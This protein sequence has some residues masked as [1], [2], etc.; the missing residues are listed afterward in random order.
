MVEGILNNKYMTLSFTKSS[1]RSFL[2]AAAVAAFVLLPHAVH[3]QSL[4][5]P[6]DPNIANPYDSAEWYCHEGGGGYGPTFGEV[7]SICTA[8]ELNGTQ[9]VGEFTITDVFGNVAEAYKTSQGGIGYVNRSITVYPG[10]PLT[11]SWSLDP[12]IFIRE[13][14]C[15]DSVLG[16]CVQ[17]NN[18][19]ASVPHYFDS[20]I[21]STFG[22]TFQYGTVTITAPSSGTATSTI[23]GKFGS[24]TSQT[25]TTGVTQSCS[26]G[27][28]G[29]PICI[30]TCPSGYH[31]GTGGGAEGG[32]S[33]SCQKT[34][35][36]PPPNIQLPLVVKVGGSAPTTP[37]PTLTISADSQSVITQQST[38]IHATF[39]AAA[40]DSLT[41]TALNV[42]LPNGVE[43]TLP[44]YGPSSSASYNYTFS[45]TTV[46][47]YIFKPYAETTNYPSWSTYGQSV[48]VTV[49]NP[50]CSN[51]SNGGATGTYPNCICNNGGAYTASTNSC[52]ALN[53]CTFN[54]LTILSGNLVT[55]YQSSSVTPPATCQS[56]IRTCTNGALSGSYAYSYCTSS[57][58]GSISSALT[59]MPSRVHPKGSTT[60]TWST[61]NMA[62]C[63]VTSSDTPTPT[64]STALSSTG[65][66]VQNITRPEVYTLFCTDN[67]DTPF[68]SKV[69]VN[70]IPVVQEL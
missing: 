51:A 10:E 1:T 36:T 6:I 14:E 55:A 33:Y 56:Q 58:A 60:L 54:G 66:L 52:A 27:G 16:L 40:G 15:T 11:Y 49:S 67:N 48:T 39:A 46:G 65:L 3:A 42:V 29:G 21:T 8:S 17:F 25:F 69:Q 68:V 45:T 35:V 43:Y 30:S 31:L 20:G 2:C 53:S 28:Q 70:L 22:Q 64:L 12:D 44:G 18:V 4:P 23:G 19:T 63:A 26:G 57:T 41:Q 24:P 62:S 34:V 50:T 7:E 47:T 37:A 5:Y 13:W 59:A 9:I 32:T 38:G 61:S